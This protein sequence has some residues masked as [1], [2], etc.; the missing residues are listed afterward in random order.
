VFGAGLKLVTPNESQRQTVVLD[1]VFSVVAPGDDFGHNGEIA[2]LKEEPRII[3]HGRDIG[4]E[5]V[6]LEI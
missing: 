3:V 2:V 4:S 5:E 6:R 1:S